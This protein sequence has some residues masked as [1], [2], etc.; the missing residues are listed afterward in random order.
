MSALGSFADVLESL[1]RVGMNT[2]PVQVHPPDLESSIGIARIRQ[3]EVEAECL[4]LVLGHTVPGEVHGGKVESGDGDLFG[5]AGIPFGSQGLASFDLP[6]VSEDRE[7]EHGLRDPESCSLKEQTL[8][9]LLVGI[10][11]HVALIHAGELE[12]CGT[13]AGLCTL[14]VHLRR[15]RSVPLRPHT[16]EIEVPEI[17]EGGGE[18][19]LAAFGE[20]FEGLSGIEIGPVLGR[21]HIA[22]SEHRGDV[23]LFSGLTVEFNR[24]GDVLPDTL[25]GH[26]ELG[27]AEHALGITGI[28]HAAEEVGRTAVLLIGALPG[29]YVH[30]FHAQ[31]FGFLGI[32]GRLSYAT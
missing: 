30:R 5:T 16:V 10:D 31:L 15:F 6:L 11:T 8:G 29:D 32:H 9:T 1:L 17:V 14:A 4:L 7:T 19:S 21:I 3:R 23:V 12:R 24:F 2:L 22:Q 25:A 26:V 28:R 13:V 18:P 27:K 20:T